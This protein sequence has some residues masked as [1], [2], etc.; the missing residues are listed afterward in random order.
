M[1]RIVLSLITAFVLAVSMAGSARA[2]CAPYVDLIEDFTPEPGGLRILRHGMV[3]M[4]DPK[5]DI[6]ARVNAANYIGFFLINLYRRAEDRKLEKLQECSHKLFGGLATD[7]PTLVEW[8]FSAGWAGWFNPL[9]KDWY[10]TQEIQR[11][12]DIVLLN[13]ERI[14]AGAGELPP[15][16]AGDPLAPESGIEGVW[17][18]VELTIV[19]EGKSQVNPL[20]TVSASFEA[21]GTFRMVLTESQSDTGRWHLDGS[22]LS[23]VEDQGDSR[24]NEYSVSFQDGTMRWEAV[25]HDGKWIERWVWQR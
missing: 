17:N 20:E 25:K 16:I 11:Q 13:A 18:G 10:T 2:D 15:V 24:I 4:H 3:M 1:F 21:D 19:I 22:V 5:Y 8:A 12:A 7:L 9:N 6:D 23:L 14:A